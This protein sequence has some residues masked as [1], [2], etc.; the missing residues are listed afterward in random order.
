ML[1]DKKSSEDRAYAEIM[2]MIL[3]QE[4][5]PGSVMMEGALAERLQMSRTPVRAALR[6]LVSSGLLEITSNRGASVPILSKKDWDDLF[7][8]RLRVEPRIAALA[9]LKY[10]GERGAFLR[11]LVEEEKKDQHEDS[12]SLQEI[13][14]RLHLGIAELADNKYMFMSLKL[15]FWRCQLYVCFFDSFLPAAKDRVMDRF[16]KPYELTSIAQ[17]ERIVDAITSKDPEQAEE[18]MKE[19]ILSTYQRSTSYSN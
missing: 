16:E 1:L 13:N 14:E 8:L 10:D 11:G 2:A 17:H 15:V 4:I 5:P 19:H 12:L 7:E 3:S 18:V 6:R 9:A